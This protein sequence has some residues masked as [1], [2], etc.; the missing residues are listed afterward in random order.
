MRGRSAD[1]RYWRG[2]AGDLPAASE[3]GSVLA[4]AMAPRHAAS[5]LALRATSVRGTMVRP[6]SAGK[7]ALATSAEG[8]LVR[9]TLNRAISGGGSLASGTSIGGVSIG[10]IDRTISVGET[11]AGGTSI[12]ATSTG[13]M[14]GT[15]SAS[16]TL[17]RGTSDR[18]I[19]D[20]GTTSPGVT[21]AAATT[22]IVTGPAS[23]ADCRTSGRGALIVSAGRGG[24]PKVRRGV[25]DQMAA[26]FA[27]LTTPRTKDSAAAND[28]GAS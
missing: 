24:S 21:L 28:A 12:R 22:V 15:I 27:A 20:S 14:D 26:A 19:S 17:D 3:T 5:A 4:Q 6:I 1:L 18:A 16:E 25:L 13:G 2:E 9:G 11:S 10:G 8:I 23:G 7:M